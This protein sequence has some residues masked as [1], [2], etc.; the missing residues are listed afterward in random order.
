MTPEERAAA[1]KRLAA[2]TDLSALFTEMQNEAI[3]TFLAD[4]SSQE[5]REAAHLM[6]RTMKKLEARVSAWAS[7]LEDQHRGND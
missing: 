5:A 2:N 7:T 6:V 4:G 1:G 3:A